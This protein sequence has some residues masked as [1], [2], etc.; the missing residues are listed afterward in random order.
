M[1]K[2]TAFLMMLAMVASFGVYAQEAAPAPAG[3]NLFDEAAS[4]GSYDFFN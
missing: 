3:G 1:K 2:I 4:I